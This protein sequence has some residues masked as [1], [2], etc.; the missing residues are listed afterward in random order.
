MPGLRVQ[1]SVQLSSP[2]YVDDDETKLLDLQTANL[3]GVTL[4]L[5]FLRQTRTR[6]APAS[7]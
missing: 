1:P 7:R 4:L 3:L 6:A 2:R 5:R